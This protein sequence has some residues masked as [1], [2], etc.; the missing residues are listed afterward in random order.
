MPPVNT[1]LRLIRDEVIV[2]VGLAD[3]PGRA[4]FAAEPGALAVIDIL[5]RHHGPWPHIAEGRAVVVAEIVIAISQAA[6]ERQRG[7]GDQR[8]LEDGSGVSRSGFH[9]G[10]LSESGYAPGVARRLSTADEDQGRVWGA[11]VLG[12]ESALRAVGRLAVLGMAP[13]D[14]GAA[15]THSKGQRPRNRKLT[16][17]DRQNSGFHR[18]IQYRFIRYS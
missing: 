1:A 3:G 10:E 11:A 2:A 18:I 4:V 8:G 7:G 12:A 6:R 13:R 17:T 15:G 16:L 14:S 5:L 9:G